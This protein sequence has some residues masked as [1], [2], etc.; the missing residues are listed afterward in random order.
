MLAL[1]RACLR[2]TAQGRRAHG[3]LCSAQRH[4]QQL[5]LTHSASWRASNEKLLQM[6]VSSATQQLTGVDLLNR[7]AQVLGIDTTLPR[8]SAAAAQMNT[9]RAVFRCCQHAH[10]AIKHTSSNRTLTA[11]GTMG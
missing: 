11:N 10:F 5:A 3:Q 1:R 9:Q 4:E 8:A 7:E 2:T 6:A